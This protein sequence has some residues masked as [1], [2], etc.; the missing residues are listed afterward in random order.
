MTFVFVI[1]TIF[2][3]NCAQVKTYLGQKNIRFKVTRKPVEQINYLTCRLNCRTEQ[4]NLKFSG[5][6]DT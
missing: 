4:F 1:I 2:S 6:S 5:G 3:S